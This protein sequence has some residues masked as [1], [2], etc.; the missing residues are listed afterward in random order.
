MK[1]TYREAAA[2]IEK[3]CQADGRFEAALI[4]FK[5]FGLDSAALMMRRDED[6]DS[7]ELREAIEKREG[8]YPLQY[9]LGEWEFFGLTFEVN[10]SCLCPRPDTETL[11][12][13]AIEF[14]PENGRFLELCTGSGCIPVSLCKHRPD[15]CGVATDLFE[16]TLATAKRNAE[17]NGVADKI[18]F[19]L[20]DLFEIEDFKKRCAAI[21]NGGFDAVISNPP[22]IPTR[23]IEDLS[24]E[25][26]HEPLAALDGGDDGLDFY[27]FIVG[28]YKS[29]LSPDG[30]ILLEIGYDQGEALCGIA[31][32]NG[33]SCEIKKD[34][35]GNDRVAILRHK[36]GGTI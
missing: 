30:V 4:F 12:E 19:L 9:I 29:L 21:P 26:K 31:E 15:A 33:F 6:F 17:K 35:G 11:V 18:D 1:L 32:I 34:F 20:A 2:R 22:Y 7:D 27:R 24:E 13:A 23:D 10:E 3:N 5:L 8:G 14:L 28:E 36:N 16:K 25:V